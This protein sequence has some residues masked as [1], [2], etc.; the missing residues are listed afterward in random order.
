MFF[1]EG[2]SYIR[3]H[4]D[5]YLINDYLSIKLGARVEQ[6]INS[7]VKD[8]AVYA[9]DICLGFGIPKPSLIAPIYTGYEKYYSVD[10]TDGEHHSLQRPKF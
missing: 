10:K 9:E 8:L 1:L 2:L 4:L 5:W 3:T 6:I 7:L